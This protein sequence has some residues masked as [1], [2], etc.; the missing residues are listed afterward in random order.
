MR[1]HLILIRHGE[2]VIEMGRK[3]GLSRNGRS[4]IARKAISLSRQIKEK[5]DIKVISSCSERCHET[6]SIFANALGTDVIL[7]NLRLKNADR[8]EFEPYQSK[9]SS[10]LS[11]FELLGIES[12]SEYASRVLALVSKHTARTVIMVSH[13]VGIRILLSQFDYHASTK[14]YQHGAISN[15]ILSMN[16]T[17]GTIGVHYG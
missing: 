6:A 15:L 11:R 14:S 8:L 16:S 4:K 17:D 7:E 10:Y 12:P 9:Y 5:E 13:E 2:P 1:R 3:Y